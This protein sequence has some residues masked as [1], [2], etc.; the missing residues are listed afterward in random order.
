[1]PLRSANLL[2]RET[3]RCNCMQ[4]AENALHVPGRVP[5]VRR[6]VLRDAGV[7]LRAAPCAGP[8]R[9][10]VPREQPSMQTVS[11]SL[12]GGARVAVRQAWLERG[13]SRL[14]RLA[15]PVLLLAGWEAFARSGYLPP[16]LLPPPTAVL[17][18]LADWTL[19]VDGSTQ[20]YSG[21]WPRHA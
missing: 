16:S 3:F 2:N 12:P 6:T 11:H 4:H 18:A 20:D 1:M 10:S 15:V 21:T 14:E 17:H 13:R 5:M 9:R 7:N 19:G 8:S